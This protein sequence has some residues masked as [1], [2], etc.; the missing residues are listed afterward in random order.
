MKFLL[1]L[2]ILNINYQIFCQEKKALNEEQQLVY[3]SF[4]ELNLEIEKKKNIL[5]NQEVDIIKQ[6]IELIG[7][8]ISMC[9]K[10][11]SY[12]EDGKI[13][14]NS[15]FEDLNFFKTQLE[16]DKKALENKKK[17]L[18]LAENKTIECKAKYEK[19]RKK[20]TNFQ[21]GKF[22]SESE[23]KTMIDKRNLEFAKQELIITEKTDKLNKLLHLEEYEKVELRLSNLEKKL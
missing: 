4:L 12:F 23:L 19:A 21:S 11:I 10:G 5:A 15:N 17:E 20:L 6:D 18:F 9:K 14:E 3:K 13:A 7:L 22:C 8:K 2:I 16:K 1:L